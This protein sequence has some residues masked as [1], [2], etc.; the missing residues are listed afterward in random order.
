MKRLVVLTALIALTA[1]TIGCGQGGFRNWCRW[2]R[3]W[4]C[5]QCQ[6]YGIEDG[7][8]YEDVVDEVEEMPAGR[9]STRD[10]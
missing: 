1:S 10:P 7:V 5:D 9:R 8:I 2:R 3:P 4:N 6:T